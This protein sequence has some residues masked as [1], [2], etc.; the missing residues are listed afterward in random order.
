MR[1]LD[2]LDRRQLSR[3]G[4]CSATRHEAPAG[5]TKLTGSLELSLA[6]DDRLGLFA[7]ERVESVGS[8]RSEIATR[9]GWYFLPVRRGTT[10]FRFLALPGTCLLWAGFV[11]GL[12]SFVP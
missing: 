12:W 3:T 10:I 1:I 11:A 6:S 9:C 8:G 5:S 2:R 7:S 4:S